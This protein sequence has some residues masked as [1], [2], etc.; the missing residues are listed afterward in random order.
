MSG[1]DKTTAWENVKWIRAHLPIWEERGMKKSFLNSIISPK[2]KG[3]E[4]DVESAIS[5]R[6][7]DFETLY[8]QPDFLQKLKE[9]CKKY[10]MPH[11]KVTKEKEENAEKEADYVFA[12]YFANKAIREERGKRAKRIENLQEH[13]KRIGYE[14]ENKVENIEEVLKI[15]V[16]RQEKCIKRNGKRTGIACY[17][18]NSLLLELYIDFIEKNYSYT[19][20]AEILEENPTTP[21][22]YVAELLASGIIESP[23]GKRCQY[24]ANEDIVKFSSGRKRVQYVPDWGWE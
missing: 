3:C 8:N 4:L 18:W 24:V 9:I 13:L 1:R 23:L 12:S 14:I 7:E 15:L 2:Y 22:K 17:S 10:R 16:D 19:K 11:G 20:M 21:P 6:L 5:C